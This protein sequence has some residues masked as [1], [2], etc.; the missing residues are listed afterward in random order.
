MQQPSAREAKLL[1][2]LGVASARY[3]ASVDAEQFEIVCQAAEELGFS[4]QKDRIPDDAW[5][6]GPCEE[7]RRN[8]HRIGVLIFA[9][10]LLA[11]D[12]HPATVEE[13][14]QLLDGEALPKA[15]LH[16][17]V[18]ELASEDPATAFQTFSAHFDGRLDDVLGKRGEAEAQLLEAVEDLETL[19]HRHF[20]LTPYE[21]DVLA[22]LAE[23]RTTLSHG[24]TFASIALSGKLLELGLKLT[25]EAHRVSYDDS[26]DLEA[27]L[28]QAMEKLPRGTVDKS[29]AALCDI[30]ARSRTVA[31]K[32]KLKQPLPSA[33]QLATAV[34]ATH[35]VLGHAI[36]GDKA[37]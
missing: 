17:Y 14:E 29:Y 22:T 36:L 10:F 37:R 27:L 3:Q 6:A 33:E 13:L 8:L 25:L 24:C 31:L 35:A 15:G 2:R 32:T 34:L 19:A 21:Q 30:V 9:L 12:G 5:F 11:P 7:S 4:C 23:L 28:R 18:D 26:W 1:V 20:G 16:R